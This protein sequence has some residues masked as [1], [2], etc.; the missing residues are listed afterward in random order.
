M[1]RRRLLADAPLDSLRF[2]RIETIT[3][4]A[5]IHV[6]RI[7]EASQLDRGLAGWIR[8]AYAGGCRKHLNAG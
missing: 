6:V 8:E 4:R 5:H 3:P 2:R 7:S 1:A